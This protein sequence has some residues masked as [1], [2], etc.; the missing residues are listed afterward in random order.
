MKLRELLRP[1]S[2]MP[3]LPDED[4]ENSSLGQKLIKSSQQKIQKKAKSEYEKSMKIGQ[5]VWST[6]ESG[7]AADER[8]TPGNMFEDCY[9]EHLA[10]LSTHSKSHSLT[11]AFDEK[12]HAAASW[13]QRNA[14]SNF[15]YRDEQHKVK[16]VETQ[17]EA[18]RFS[19][20]LCGEIKN[21]SIR[22][23]TANHESVGSRT[24][25]GSGAW[26]PGNR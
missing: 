4:N 5:A 1:P 25:L 26:V 12:R 3:V 18:G 20:A 6:P 15:G 21:R 16:K 9:D 19:Q 2:S 22:T 8:N 24:S 23:T 17:H 10:A 11:A 7:K 13:N 14:S